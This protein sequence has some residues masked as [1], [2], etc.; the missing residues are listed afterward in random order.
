MKRPIAGFAC[1]I[2]RRTSSGAAEQ[3]GNVCGPV[4][5]VQRARARRR[6]AGRNDAR[7]PGHD[8]PQVGRVVAD[9]AGRHRHVVAKLPLHADVPRMHARRCRDPTAAR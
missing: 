9:V 3:L 6:G 2:S 4:G 8:V 1:V 5:G 7:V